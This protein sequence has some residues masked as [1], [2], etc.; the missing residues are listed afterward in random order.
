MKLS[1]LV[2]GSC[3]MFVMGAGAQ[4]DET[5]FPEKPVVV[6]VPYSPGGGSDNVSR[7]MARYLTEQWGKT[8]VVENKPGADGLI[9]TNETIRAK[10]DGYT[11]LVSIPAIAM[12]KY[13]NKSI[14]TDPLTQLTPVSMM[15]TGPTAIV[16]KGKTDIKTVADY[17]RYCANEAN[18]CSWASGEPFTLM[19]GT[20]L[21]SEL[22]LT[23]KVTNVRYAG[24]SAAVSDVIGGHVTS[25]VTGT[26]SVLSAHK[27]GDLRILAVSADKRLVELPDVPT[28]AEAGLGDV[29]FTNNWYGIFAPAGTPE[30]IKKKIADGFNKAANAPEVLKVLKPLLLSPVGSSPEEFARQLAQ[31]QKVIDA[32]AASVFSEK[33][34]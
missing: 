16:V 11:L 15:A 26:S 20:G 30:P 9:A 14:K 18:N 24:T 34:N 10:P 6:I 21:M 2:L 28:Y 8:V 33:V 22:A 23:G 27:S 25:L 19:V 7:A 3:L 32:S 4:A 12:L 13:T 1:R 31:D 29:K 17:K 5:K